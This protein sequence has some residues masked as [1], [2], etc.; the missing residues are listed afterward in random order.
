M[1]S[2]RHAPPTRLRA[3]QS[4]Q[5]LATRKEPWSFRFLPFAFSHRRPHRYNTALL[6]Y[7]RLASLT[8][9]AD[10]FALL[11]PRASLSI[12]IASLSL[13]HP[14]ALP[15]SIL[16]TRLP[17]SASESRRR[18]RTA[19]AMPPKA[20]RSSGV[21][22]ARRT[23]PGDVQGESSS[24][25]QACQLPASDAPELTTG[26]RCLLLAGDPVPIRPKRRYRP[27]TVALREIRQYQSGTKLLLLK[28]PFMRL[29]GPNLEPCWIPLDRS[30]TCAS[31]AT[32]SEKLA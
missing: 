6:F 3:S 31:H 27:G 16:R 24:L 11:G 14:A 5:A 22:T 8:S 17:H 2:A 4:P 18:I 20:R 15:E 10:E 1:I 7:F 30:L 29:V 21:T 13:L 9:H 25:R 28:L 23:R 19:A 12:D 26:A 32:R